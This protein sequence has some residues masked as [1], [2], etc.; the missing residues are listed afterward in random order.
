MMMIKGLVDEKLVID[1]VYRFDED[2]DEKVVF[3]SFWVGV[4]LMMKIMKKRMKVEGR[5]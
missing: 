4:L 5:R 2:N 1:Y 3:F